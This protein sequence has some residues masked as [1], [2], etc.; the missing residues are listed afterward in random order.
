MNLKDLLIKKKQVVIEKWFNLIISSY[1]PDTAHYLRN[2]KNQFTN[3]VGHAI[4][5]AIEGI[6][7][8][9]INPSDSGR[10]TTYLD[11]VIR[12]RA[13]QDF[14]PSVALNFLFLL[15]EI[16]RLELKEELHEHNLF[17]ELLIFE[18][19]IDGLL[20]ESFDIYMSCREKIYEL[21]AN[22]VKNLTYRLL[23]SA[24][25]IKEAEERI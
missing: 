5:T 18:S 14:A 15:K 16:V 25:L 9:L 12:I 2:Q 17:D 3:P 10:I 24:D 20:K 7:D 19:W 23:K 21:G 22:E 11:N 8:E 13:I 6:F 4:H 1:P